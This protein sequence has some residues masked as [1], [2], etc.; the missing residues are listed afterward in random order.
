MEDTVLLRAANNEANSPHVAFD[1]GP[2]YGLLSECLS[3]SPV[4]R[5]IFSASI[6]CDTD[7]KYVIFVGERHIEIRHLS[8]RLNLELLA[9][10][11]DFFCKIRSAG[12]IDLRKKVD[13]LNQIKQEDGSTPL[14]SS[15]SASLKVPK[16]VLVIA[17]E[18]GDLAFVYIDGSRGARLEFIVSTQRLSPTL[19]Q[20]CHVGKAISVDPLSRAIA[21]CAWEGSFKLYETNDA[22]G[23]EQRLANGQSFIPLRHEKTFQVPGTIVHLEFLRAKEENLVVFV[24]LFVNK[25]RQ[26]RV[27]L[28]EWNTAEP[29]SRAAQLGQDGLRIPERWGLPLHIIPLTI[30]TFFAMICERSICVGKAIDITNGNC[31]WQQFPIPI[32]ANRDQNLVT[33]WARP[34]RNADYAQRNDDFYVVKENGELFWIYVNHSSGSYGPNIETVKSGKLAGTV[35]TALTF[36]EI[37]TPTSSDLLVAAGEGSAGGTYM[38]TP[39]RPNTPSNRDPLFIQEIFNWSPMFDMDILN[40]KTADRSNLSAS[41]GRLYACTGFGEHGAIAEVRHGI[42]CRPA[43]AIEHNEPV[44]KVIPLP[45]SAGTGCFVLLCLVL[46]TSLWYL[47]Y[48]TLDASDAADVISLRTGDNVQTLTA[49]VVKGRAVQVT[50]E[51]VYSTTLNEV[52]VEADIQVPTPRQEWDCPAGYSV[53]SAALGGDTVVLVLKSDSG[54]QLWNME[55]QPISNGDQEEFLKKRGESLDIS[56]QPTHL[57]FLNISGKPYL[58]E[59]SSTLNLYELNPDGLLAPRAQISTTEIDEDPNCTQAQSP[60]CESV[61][62]LESGGKTFLLCGLRNG[63]VFYGEIDTGTLKFNPLKRVK[64]GRLPVMLSVRGDTPDKALAHS[65]FSLFQLSIEESELVVSSVVFNQTVEPSVEAFCHLNHDFRSTQFPDP[66]ICATDSSIIVAMT[67]R[68]PTICTRQLE[69]KET[70]SRIIYNDKEDLLAVVC[71]QASYESPSLETGRSLRSPRA[72]VLFLDPKTGQSQAP[73]ELRDGKYDEL[74]FNKKDEKIHCLCNWTFP[75]E[76]VSW[77]CILVGTSYEVTEKLPRKGRVVV[78]SLRYVKSGT[79]R[80]LEIRKRNQILC[81]EPVHSLATYGKASVIYG[82]EKTLSK[83]D[84]VRNTTG[85]WKFENQTVQNVDSTP[86]QITT[87]DEDQIISVSS[88]RDALAIYRVKEDPSP[89][90]ERV[91]SDDQERAG[92]SHLHIKENFFIAA[93][94]D[95]GI[96][97]LWMPTECRVTTCLTR[98]FEAHLPNSIASLRM[99]DLRAPWRPRNLELPGVISPNSDIIG[100]CF[101]GAIYKF[102]ILNEEATKLLAYLQKCYIKATYPPGNSKPLDHREVEMMKEG[103]LKHI[104]GGLLAEA[105]KRTD[106]EWLKEA[107]RDR[108]VFEELVFAVYKSAGVE[109]A[110]G[111]DRGLDDVVVEYLK[112]L[113]GGVVL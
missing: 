13:F 32:V 8:K 67:S 30:P 45:G 86:L 74:I 58:V 40:L 18:S 31:K 100:T 101:D 109:V 99:G 50:T 44:T 36:H 15:S 64:V 113:L 77:N 42:E 97:G 9:T 46:G 65:T 91:Y 55:L 81:P 54:Y 68:M 105:L 29:L 112:G 102:T 21:V 63:Y 6:R 23:L 84:L 108:E 103:S 7:D 93:D 11:S 82:T 80:K 107:M 57:D 59:A 104:S 35:G 90:L 39:K 10:K 19:S 5:S 24:V 69:L 28:Y 4:I 73:R 1:T 26:A 71:H 62:L 70:P 61:C 110:L 48:N 16:Q 14:P 94:R 37:R 72:T 92:R 88:T 60:V 51:G 111:D 47:P 17:L 34:H 20:A 12:L 83:I 27:L 76:S 56:S 79:E 78:L 95:E 3:P 89:S 66:I 2:K 75:D 53:V 87:R 106:G 25:L 38:I 96:V 41:R 98:V 33:A 43:T 22:A 85:Q 49:G 52:D